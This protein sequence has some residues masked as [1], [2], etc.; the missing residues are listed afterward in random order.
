MCRRENPLS[1]DNKALRELQEWLREHRANTGQKYRDLAVRAGCH[2]T[3]LQRAASGETVPPLQTVL[4]YARACDACPEEARRLWKAA[5]YEA[6]RMARGGRG[7]PAPRPKLVR[8]F[9]DLSAALRDLYERAGSPTLRV[10]EQRAGKFGV[11]P[12]STAHRIAT[13]QTVPRSLSQ[14]QAYLRACEVPEA[15]WLVWEAAWTR[16]WRHEKQED[17]GSVAIPVEQRAGRPGRSSVSSSTSRHTT[18]LPVSEADLLESLVLNWRGSRRPRG[19]GPS[20]HWTEVRRMIKALE[21]LGNYVSVDSQGSEVLHAAL[22]PG[23]HVRSTKA[24]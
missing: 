3:T 23:L 20:V 17:E 15:D 14:F 10:M 16:A 13:K 9:V 7:V 1:T 21:I 2:A 24:G 11:L 5:R 4:N 22:E 12:R 6:S 18:A 8:D 19:P